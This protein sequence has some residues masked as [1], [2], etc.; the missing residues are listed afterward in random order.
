M[1]D[2]KKFS[3]PLFERAF[4]A[5][6]ILSTCTDEPLAFGG[7]IKGFVQSSTLVTK[8]RVAASANAEIAA[9]TSSHDH[10]SLPFRAVAARNWD[11]PVSGL[12]FFA[13]VITNEHGDVLHRLEVAGLDPGTQLE[14]LSDDSQ[15]YDYRDEDRGR[16]FLWT[17][18]E[19][20]RVALL[21]DRVYGMEIDVSTEGVQAFFVEPSNAGLA[22]EPLV[23]PPGKPGLPSDEF[24]ED[25]VTEIEAMA[26]SPSVIERL[27]AHALSVRLL[28]VEADS[29]SLSHWWQSLRASQRA[30]WLHTTF[31]LLSLI[32]DTWEELIE[33]TAQEG[34]ES[35]DELAADPAQLQNARIARISMQRVWLDQL[36]WLFDERELNEALYQ[37][38][39]T[40]DVSLYRLPF[41]VEPRVQ[42]DVMFQSFVLSALANQAEPWWY[43][44]HAMHANEFDEPEP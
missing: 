8:D 30:S 29:T 7:S 5:E 11:D 4:G 19:S 16:W 41:P 15:V 2:P 31:S 28:G 35:D 22:F 13:S 14:W 21:F 36:A 12:S 20:C 17:A 38:D 23:F 1:T 27:A 25:L 24:D 3:Y 10:G 37:I 33:A 32:E 44:V 43:L 6:Y 34:I 18:S 26:N 39:Q 9:W 40:V 42:S